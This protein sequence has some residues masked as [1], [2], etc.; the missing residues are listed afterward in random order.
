M[1]SHIWPLKKTEMNFNS[2]MLLEQE[3]KITILANFRYSWYYII[4]QCCHI[5]NVSCRYPMKLSGL[6][7]GLKLFIYF[8]NIY[9]N[10]NKYAIV[11]EMRGNAWIE[12]S[13]FLYEQQIQGKLSN[14]VNGWGSE[15]GFYLSFSLLL[16]HWSYT[17]EGK[18]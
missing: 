11:L 16:P 12:H 9:W 3:T 15:E 1:V 8:C 10:H 2:Q 18:S 4:L 13:N 17:M 6:G 7:G 14:P 5:E